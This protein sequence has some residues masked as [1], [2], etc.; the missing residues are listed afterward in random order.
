MHNSTVLIIASAA[1]ATVA[2]PIYNDYAVL[3]R[4]KLWTS[5]LAPSAAYATRVAIPM[6][7][8]HTNSLTVTVP[9]EWVS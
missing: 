3:D 2:A 7:P 1:T 5:A 8:F 6:P 9:D 4:S